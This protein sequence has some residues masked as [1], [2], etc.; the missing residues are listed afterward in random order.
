MCVAIVGGNE[1]MERRYIDTCRK[2]GCKARVYVKSRGD[3]TRRFGSPDLVILFTKT[4][5]HKMKDIAMAEAKRCNASVACVHSSS[6]SALLE[7]METYCGK[8]GA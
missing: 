7:V 5:S 2:Y 3:I 6:M 8:A 4:V 1:C